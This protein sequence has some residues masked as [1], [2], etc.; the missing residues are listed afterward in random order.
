MQQ[1]GGLAR[2]MRAPTP[3][4]AVEVRELLRVVAGSGDSRR[5]AILVAVQQCQKIEGLVPCRR[6][7]LWS[8][9]WVLASTSASGGGAGASRES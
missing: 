1:G 6:V 2:E 5:S 9:W 3:A 8:P 4:L 7:W